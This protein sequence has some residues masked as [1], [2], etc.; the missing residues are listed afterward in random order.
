V[1]LPAYGGSENNTNNGVIRG[2][3]EYKTAL[4]GNS[5]GAGIY[6]AAFAE[7]PIGITQSDVRAGDFDMLV[8]G[9][10]NVGGAHS[11][12]VYASNDG[13]GTVTDL[14]GIYLCCEGTGG[15]GG[16]VSHL[17]GIEIPDGSL[18]SPEAI[19]QVGIRIGN[20]GDAA[21]MWA[22]KTGTG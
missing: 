1:N 5:G 3:A 18:Y 11:I 12:F 16:N 21:N 2:V 9:A 10:G 15:G 20:L 17:S 6:G 4:N 22:I 14:A 13:S 7:P 8:S 19:D